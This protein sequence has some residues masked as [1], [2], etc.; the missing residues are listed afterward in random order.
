MSDARLKS[1]D[2]FN[3]FQPIPRAGLPEDISNLAIYLASDESSFVTGQDFVV[4]GGLLAGR[5]INVASQSFKKINSYL[6]SF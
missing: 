4:D 3:D 6:K 2:A 5:P 1:S